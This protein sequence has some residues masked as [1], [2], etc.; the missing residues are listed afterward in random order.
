MLKEQ[1]WRLCLAAPTQSQ[2]PGWRYYSREAGAF[3]TLHILY[4]PLCAVLKAGWSRFH[5]FPEAACFLP[6]RRA[7]L[8]T[9]RFEAH[10][11]VAQ[12]IWQEHSS[13]AVSKQQKDE[14]TSS[15]PN[16]CIGGTCVFLWDV[17]RL[18]YDSVWYV[19]G[20]LRLFCIL[21][22]HLEFTPL[23]CSPEKN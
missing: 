11:N 16:L 10:L 17:M 20:F 9:A 18:P 5:S 2:Y 22:W 19:L 1:W 7:A 14:H 12:R 15:L 3:I 4:Q 23:L 21:E 8:T 6:T 13:E